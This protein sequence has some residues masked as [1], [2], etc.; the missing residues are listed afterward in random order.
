L[1]RIL[2][3]LLLLISQ[4]L[5]TG[6]VDAGTVVI[7]SWRTDDKALW[8][9]V[10]IPAFQRRHIGIEMKYQASAPTEYDAGL[11]ARFANG[12][13]GDL[14]ACRPF[15]VA[16]NL[17]KNGYLE[18]L[19]GKA[20]MENFPLTALVAWQTEDAQTTYCMPVAS[21]IHGF[22]YNKK[23]F[24]K[25]NLQ[26]PKTQ[27]EFFA[28]LEAVKKQGA[29]HPLALGTAEKWEATQTV[30]L[31]IG[32]NFWHG[33][34]GRKALINGTAKFTDKE[35][36]SALEYQAKLGKYL[37]KDAATQTYSESQQLFAAGRAAIYPLGSWDISYFNQ[38]AG[39]EFGVFAPP[40]QNSGDQCYI[41][42]H[43]DIGIGVN[44]KSKNKEDA[45]RFLEWLGSQEFADLYT[46]RATGFFHCRIT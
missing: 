40:V 4:L 5:L 9:S 29:Y 2:C 19:D 6:F 38:I 1:L 10:L 34:A 44:K 37:A 8:E 42:D 23:I 36:V 24:R 14:V 11:S 41:L 21:V 43:M 7:E 39:L 27:A 12:T 25:L 18:K 46:N 16:Q 45:Y 17:Y 22:L 35:F 13:A 30:F 26:P 3:A 15:Q 20:G 28:V 33:E 31:S 32:P